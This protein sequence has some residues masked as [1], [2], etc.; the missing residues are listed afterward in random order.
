MIS[1]S[2]W[3][4]HISIFNASSGYALLWPQSFL[5]TALRVEL[6]A[7]L[8]GAKLA[9]P[10][11]SIRPRDCRP[12]AKTPSRQTCEHSPRKRLPALLSPRS[13]GGRGDSSPPVAIVGRAEPNSWVDARAIQLAG[14]RI[15]PACA[16]FVHKLK[17][18]TAGTI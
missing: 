12:Q 15:S 1:L 4:I 18:Q 7:C 9:L 6:S 5:Q 3:H 13:L 14:R 17:I 8:L 2:T 16:H 10:D 11:S